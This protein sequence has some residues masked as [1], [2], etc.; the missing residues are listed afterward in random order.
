M[1]TSGTKTTVRLVSVDAD[2]AGRRLDNFLLAEMKGLPR[3]RV[4]RLIR[5]GEVRVNK[6]RSKPT[7]RLAEGDVVRIPPVLVLKAGEVHQPERSKIKWILEQI[8]HEDDHLLVLNKPSGLAVHGGSGISLGAIELLRAARPDCRY[9]E[10]VHRL[11]RDTS[12]CLLVAKKRSALR[13]MH[14]QWR[15]GQVGKVYLALLCG[16]WKGDWRQVDFPL[17]VEHRKN[18]ERHVRT[19]ADGK[20]ASTRFFPQESFE[21][22]CLSRIE[23]LTG[24]THQI[25][26][27]ASA[28]GHPVAGDARYGDDENDPSGLQR[29]F[30]HAHTLSF[31]HPA[32]D[33]QVSFTADLPEALNA[34]L[35][36]L[37]QD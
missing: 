2:S 32:D 31:L 18:G 25:R 22:F 12:G 9:L 11:D 10:L 37:R 21:R 23:L 1:A 26:V 30:L 8:L 13:N 16:N 3:T 27:H 36:Q 14:A 28:I 15:E 33:N 6:G 20:P 29:L 19:G 17:L 24:R 35:A 4:Y 7:T 5:K 34:V